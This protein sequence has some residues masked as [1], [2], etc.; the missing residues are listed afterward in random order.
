MEETEE[1]L[2]GMSQDA[3]VEALAYAQLRALPPPGDQPFL[4]QVAKV[5]GDLQPGCNRPLGGLDTMVEGDRIGRAGGLDILGVS[6]ERDDAVAHELVQAPA[7][8]GNR[9]ADH[10][11]VGAD[12]CGEPLLADDL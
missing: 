7:R 11:I 6:V 12:E 2:A 10:A 1:G 4:C 9:S 3:D 8:R 5:T